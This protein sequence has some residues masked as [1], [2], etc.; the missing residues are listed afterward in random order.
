MKWRFSDGAPI[1]SQI[2]SQL[3]A[4]IVSGELAAGQKLESVRDMAMEA[5]VNPNT[6]QR[7]LGELER[8]GLVYSRR[9]S[10]RFVAEDDSVIK[11]AK[12]ALA[13]ERITD[14]LDLMTKLGYGRDEIA[15]MISG[16]EGGKE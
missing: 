4:A 8:E 2:V 9:T 6:M 3:T 16:E 13:R 15:S 7:A 5:G 1:Y 10:G 14:F 12:N 11:D